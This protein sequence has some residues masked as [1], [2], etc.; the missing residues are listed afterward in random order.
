MRLK[1]PAVPGY[2]WSPSGGRH[3]GLLAE[4]FKSLKL[5]VGHFSQPA[6]NFER[7]YE[8]LL[9]VWHCA[10]FSDFVEDFADTLAGLMQRDTG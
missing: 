4:A 2:L 6:S 1:R 5:G 9:L 3:P 8:E 10:V 7:C